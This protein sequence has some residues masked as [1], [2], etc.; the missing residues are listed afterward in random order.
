MHDRAPGAGALNCDARRRMATN[1][2]LC[3][4]AHGWE[5]VLSPPLVRV[6]VGESFVI[7]GGRID[8]EYRRYALE[9]QPVRDVVESQRLVAAPLRTVRTAEAGNS[10]AVTVDGDRGHE[11]AFGAD[12]GIDHLRRFD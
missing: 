2:L 9:P 4:V 12:G 5:A 11:C 10:K 7:G 1:Q 6:R 3:T 8:A